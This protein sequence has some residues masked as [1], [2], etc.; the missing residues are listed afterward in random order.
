MY[1][2]WLI[3][4]KK[5]EKNLS[6]LEN[7]EEEKSWISS[8]NEVQGWKENSAAE[9]CEGQKK[10]DSLDGGITKKTRNYKKKERL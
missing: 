6:A 9:T 4:G 8:K 2:F 5:N 3:S 10:T 1:I 7:K